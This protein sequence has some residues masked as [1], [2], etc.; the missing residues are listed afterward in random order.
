VRANGGQRNAFAVGRAVA[1]RRELLGALA[2]HLLKLLRLGNGIDQA[3]VHGALA[4][5]AFGRGAEDVCKVMA[6]MALVGDAGQAAG[7][8]QHTQQRHLGQRNSG[9]AVVD[10]HD[11]VAGQ[12]QFVAAAGAGAIDRRDELQAG[13]A[14]GVLDAVAGFIRE[15][16]EV[17]LPGVAGQAQHENVGARAEGAVTRA[18]DHHGAH[19]GVLEADAVQG[20]IQLDVDT[21]VVRVE[22]ELVAGADAAV[23][24]NVDEQGRDGALEGQLDVLVLGRAGLVFNDRVRRHGGLLTGKVGKKWGLNQCSGLQ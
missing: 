18:G 9:G 14:A 21:E 3:P 6:H 10:Q 20:V 12:G 23:F 17:D 11:V 8:R 1:L 2:H 24:G 19:F 22:L 16:A 7:A 13:M 5:H 4:A 15:F